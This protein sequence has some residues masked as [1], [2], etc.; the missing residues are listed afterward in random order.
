MYAQ[1]EGNMILLQKMIRIEQDHEKD[2]YPNLVLNIF[3]VMWD[4]IFIY[5]Y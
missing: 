5:T 2:M 1:C 3:K 4:S